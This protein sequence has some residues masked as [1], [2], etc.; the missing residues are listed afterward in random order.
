[1][2]KARRA[3][4]PRRPH[5]GGALQQWRGGGGER[6]QDRAAGDR[7]AGGDLLHRAFH[8]RTLLCLS[9]TSKTGYKLGCGPFAPEIHRLPYPNHFRD[10]HG[11]PLEAFVARRLAGVEEAFLN[12]VPA[13]HVAAIVIEPVLGE[14]GFLPA[15]ASYLHGL[16]EICDRHGILLILD[17][18]QSGFGRTGRWAAYEHAGIVPDLSTWAKALGGG[19]PISA[20]LGKAA[21][22][23]AALPGT[24]GGTF[25]GNPVACA[26]ALATLESMEALDINERGAR[27]G[28]TIRARFEKLK[29]RST[30]VG[31]VRGLGAMIGLELCYDRDP[32]RPAKE[33]VTA[34]TAA[35]L[36]RGVLVL[37]AGPHGNVLRVLSP[38]VISDTDLA[39][40]L[41]AI[42]EAVLAAPHRPKGNA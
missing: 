23:D 25:G 16:R 2:R 10:G 30:L 5:Q 40:G 22:I 1:M 3:A 32:A 42:E 4:P 38:L 26:A 9:L 35:C 24:I 7:A 41:D 29:E 33:A 6:D 31:D 34:V 17:E 14:G 36:A 39:R 15:P 13:Q 21:V 12:V 20:V 19:M 11:L 8:G 18:V 28:R 37:P 27:V